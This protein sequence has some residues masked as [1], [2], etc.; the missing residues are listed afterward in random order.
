VTILILSRRMG[1]AL[2]L[3]LLLVLP[4]L[5]SVGCHTSGV[6]KAVLLPQADRS[7]VNSVAVDQRVVALSF[8]AQ[9]GA[10]RTLPL[11]DVLQKH[12]VRATFFLP[13]FWAEEHPLVAREIAARGHELGLDSATHPH[14]T[15]LGMEDIRRELLEN[16]RVLQEVTG[17]RPRLFR[18][19]YGEY[20]DRVIQTAESEGFVT[21]GWNLD[22]RNRKREGEPALLIVRRVLQSVEPGDIIVFDCNSESTQAAVDVVLT[23]LGSDG[24]RVLSISQL[25]SEG[26]HPTHREGR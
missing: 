1:I 24:Y 15:S 19:P 8:N 16:Y 13:S 3:M 7:P 4:W 6:V 14:M 2:L 9:W 12:G 25:I 5:Y 10:E 18:P 11:L 17:A 20:N 23:Q 22:A 26:A 21:V